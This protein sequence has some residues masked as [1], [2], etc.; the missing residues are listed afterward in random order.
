VE[1][2]THDLAESYWEGLPEKVKV[3]YAKSHELH[4]KES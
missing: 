3:L 4:F 2:K 1:S